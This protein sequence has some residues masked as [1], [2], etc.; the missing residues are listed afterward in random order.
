LRCEGPY[1]EEASWRFVG[2]EAREK[3]MM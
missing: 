3:V 2:E 1:S